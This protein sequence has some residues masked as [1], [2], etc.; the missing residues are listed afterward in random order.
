M[1]SEREISWIKALVEEIEQASRTAAMG[2]GGD[3]DRD[4]AKTVLWDY[5]DRRQTPSLASERMEPQIEGREV[6]YY[7]ASGNVVRYRVTPQGVFRVFS[8]PDEKAEWERKM[9]ITTNRL[10]GWR[11]DGTI[12]NF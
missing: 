5:L 12:L 4:R 1:L 8:S 3:E 10:M 6:D 9:E 2:L 11:D 7:D